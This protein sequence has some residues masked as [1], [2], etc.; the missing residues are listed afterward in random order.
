MMAQTIAVDISPAGTVVIEANGFRGAGC[1]KATEQLELVL[2]GGAAKKD[3]KPEYSL[4]NTNMQQ[5]NIK[6]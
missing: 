4:P 3:R 2:G 6:Y 1:E 5:N